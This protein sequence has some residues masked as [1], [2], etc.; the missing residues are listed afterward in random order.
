M[1]NQN[2]CAISVRTVA[3]F[4]LLVVLMLAITSSAFAGKVII[5]ND[6]I[7]DNLVSLPEPISDDTNPDQFMLNSDRAF[8]V[9][10]PFQ[11]VHHDP[12]TMDIS[13]GEGLIIASNLCDGGDDMDLSDVDSVLWEA[14]FGA[15]HIVNDS[16][17]G[18]VTNYVDNGGSHLGHTHYRMQFGSV[19]NA[20]A[21][22]R[23]FSIVKHTATGQEVVLASNPNVGLEPFNVYDFEMRRNGTTGDISVSIVNAASGFYGNGPGVGEII[24]ETVNDT[25]LAGGAIGLFQ[26]NMI[27]GQWDNLMVPEPNAMALAGMGC[28]GLF[29]FYGMRQRRQ[30]AVHTLL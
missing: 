28:L 5:P 6:C 24:N 1:R 30:V 23:G 12:L 26:S 7:R 11:V 9:F 15:G 25:S 17:V 20:T 16:V 8:P 2:L 3:M 29:V 10:G 27:D 19:N 18:L 22:D 4:A 14:T 21:S 13:R